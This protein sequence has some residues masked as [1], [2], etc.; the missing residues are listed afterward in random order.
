MNSVDPRI[1]SQLSAHDFKVEE[2]RQAINAMDKR[3]E[4]LAVL[5]REYAAE[6]SQAKARLDEL[7]LQIRRAELEVADLHHQSKVHQGHLNEITD[8]REYRALN[9]EIRYIQPLQFFYH[10]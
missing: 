4:T 1:L 6:T 2:C 7:K 9:E 10:Y 5:E 3:R 8:S